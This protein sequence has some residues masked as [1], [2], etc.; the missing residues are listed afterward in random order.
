MIIPNGWGIMLKGIRFLNRHNWSRRSLWLR[1][2]LKLSKWH[3]CLY[4]I[5]SGYRRRKMTMGLML[6]LWSVWS[7]SKFRN[8]LH[9]LKKLPSIWWSAGKHLISLRMSLQYLT[10]LMKKRH[11]IILVNYFEPIWRKY[12]RIWTEKLL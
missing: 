4:L 11:S 10:I 7:I 1:T 6:W 3:I 9:S 12:F 8:K 2:L 5:S